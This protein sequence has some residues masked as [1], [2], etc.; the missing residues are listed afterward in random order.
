ATAEAW[1]K[2]PVHATSTPGFIVNRVARPFYAEGLRLLE[3][4][5]ADAA[6][7]DAVMREAG[8]FRMGPFELMDLIGHDVNFAVTSSVFQAYFCDP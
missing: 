4:R 2:V 5:A 3:E 7:I 6:T 1:G 8:G